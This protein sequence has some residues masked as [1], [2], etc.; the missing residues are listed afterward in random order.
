V[1]GEVVGDDGDGVGR[2][3]TGVGAGGSISFFAFAA[4]ASGDEDERRSGGKERSD[5]HWWS[6]DY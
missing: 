1:E 5:G 2:R 4:R 3:V 6:V